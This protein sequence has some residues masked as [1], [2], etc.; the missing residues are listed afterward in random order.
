VTT[1]GTKHKGGIRQEY[2]SSLG[3]WTDFFL[4]K[5]CDFKVVTFS[6]NIGRLLYE[7]SGYDTNYFPSPVISVD[8]RYGGFGRQ[9]QIPPKVTKSDSKP[10][11]DK[12]FLKFQK[13]DA[14]HFRGFEV[15]YS[16]G[17][18]KRTMR[19]GKFSVFDVTDQLTPVN[20]TLC[21]DYKNEPSFS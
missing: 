8:M 15:P 18:N 9:R 2:T 7:M 13:G 17:R 6:S 14:I 20:Y 5:D 16:I 10:T 4:L 21:S 1:A 11:E 19:V 12:S 3:F